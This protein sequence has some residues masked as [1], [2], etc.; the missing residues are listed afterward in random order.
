MK[1]GD[2]FRNTPWGNEGTIVRML[3]GGKAIIK[4]NNPGYGIGPY[5][6]HTVDREILEV[7]DAFTPDGFD[8]VRLHTRK[9]AELTKPLTYQEG[10]DVGYAMGKTDAKAEQEKS[11][12]VIN[13]GRLLNELYHDRS[14]LERVVKDAVA[15]IKYALDQFEEEGK[16]SEWM[17]GKLEEF[18]DL[19]D[20]N[21]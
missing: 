19:N 7:I 17:L 13:R 11:E 6:E 14:R 21:T 5:Q 2:K 15:T 9:K 8:R 16:V 4:Y 10:Y 18:V 20:T 3:A 1:S 12:L